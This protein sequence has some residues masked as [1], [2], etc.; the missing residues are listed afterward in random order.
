MPARMQKAVDAHT[1][2]YDAFLGVARP[3][4]RPL[5]PKPQTLNPKPQ[6]QTLA[7]RPLTLNPKP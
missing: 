3:H 1:K 5:N 2:E 7:P 4:I 6:S